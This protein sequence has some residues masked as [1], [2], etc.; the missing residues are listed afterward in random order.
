MQISKD[1][2]IW[3]I[4]YAKSKWE[5]SNYDGISVLIPLAFLVRETVD[6]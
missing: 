2:E 6:L 4:I 1:C 5:E 3:T